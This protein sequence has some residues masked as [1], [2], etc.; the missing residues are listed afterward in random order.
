MLL[1]VLMLFHFF[2]CITLSIYF[3][4]IHTNTVPKQSN[5]LFFNFI[6]SRIM[7]WRK[8]YA[9]AHFLWHIFLFTKVQLT[10]AHLSFDTYNSDMHSS[11]YNFSFDWHEAPKILKCTTKR[12]SHLFISYRRTNLIVKQM[13]KTKGQKTSKPTENHKTWIVTKTTTKTHHFRNELNV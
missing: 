5:K 10:L 9:N 7:F 8:K 13:H 6:Y 2:T 11:K 3:F 1:N 4:H 12:A